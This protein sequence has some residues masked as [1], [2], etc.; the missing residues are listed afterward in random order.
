MLT[1]TQNCE[2]AILFIFNSCIDNDD[3]VVEDFSIIIQLFY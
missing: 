1:E 3:R 2:A